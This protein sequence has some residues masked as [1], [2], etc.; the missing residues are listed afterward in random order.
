[1][2]IE[3]LR[4]DP[5]CCEIVAQGN[6]LLVALALVAAQREHLEVLE[7][8]E[9][10]KRGAGAGAAAPGRVT[11]ALLASLSAQATNALKAKEL[12]DTALVKAR[13]VKVRSQ[14][15]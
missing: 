7:A 1:M 2:E 9:A 5:G 12:E 14:Q 3:K 15:R 6:A 8:I 11:Q 4:A 13:S 10:Q